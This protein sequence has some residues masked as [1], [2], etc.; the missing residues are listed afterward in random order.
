MFRQ[1]QS[2]YCTFWLVALTLQAARHELPTQSV[3]QYARPSAGE[4]HEGKRMTGRRRVPKDRRRS[5]GNAV[6]RGS[7][8]GTVER[9]PRLTSLTKL[10]LSPLDAGCRGAASSG[11]A[12]NHLTQG[13]DPERCAAATLPV[14]A[15]GDWSHAPPCAA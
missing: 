7:L 4:Q 12:V 10:A 13:A 1:T 15:R 9:S 3:Q 11:A 6:G 8:P 2:L 14:V 5:T